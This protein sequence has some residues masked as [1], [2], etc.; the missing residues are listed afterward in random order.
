MKQASKGFTILSGILY[1][2]LGIY[3]LNAPAAA[4]LAYVYYIGFATL[5]SGILG[6]IY[7]FKGQRENGVLFMSILD[8]IFGIMFFA[9]Q[10]I[11]LF[12]TLGLPFFIGIWAIFRGI[13]E[14]VNAIQTR[15]KHWVWKLIWGILLVFSGIFFL[16]NP[17]ISLFTVVQYFGIFAV[18]VGIMWIIDGI[19]RFFTKK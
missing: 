12:M 10:G 8:I 15:D 17:L 14:I 19:V 4:L 3:T 6:L 2:I 5:F 1:L 11:P 13:I 18:V 16:N 7:Y 9:F